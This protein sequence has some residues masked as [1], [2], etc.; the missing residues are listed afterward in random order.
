[1]AT[2]LPY[3]PEHLLRAVLLTRKHRYTL[4]P[5]VGGSS[6]SNVRD[7]ATSMNDEKDLDIFLPELT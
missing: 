2:P 3:S 7:T 5:D 1:M 4:I 6:V